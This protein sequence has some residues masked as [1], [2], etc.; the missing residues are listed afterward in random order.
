MKGFYNLTDKLKDALLAE[1]FVNTVTF[2]S[3]DDVDLNKQTIFPLSHIIVNNTTV[4]S[5][6]LTFNVSILAMDIVDISKDETTDIFVG[7]DN[8]QDVLNTQLGLLTRIIN[9]LQ[10][11]DLFTELYQVQGDVSCEP[12]VDRF[13]NKLAGWAATFDVLVQNDMTIC[14]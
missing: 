5:K 10:R 12:F 9:I 4:S 14:S 13:D 6:T 2:G 1:P 11:G 7:N 3:L 8:E